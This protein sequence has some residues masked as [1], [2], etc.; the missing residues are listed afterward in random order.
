MRGI[1]QVAAAALLLHINTL[2]QSP[3][4]RNTAFSKDVEPILKRKCVMCHNEKLKQNGLRLDDPEAALAGGYSGPVILP[5]QSAKSKLI[6][7][8]TSTKKDFMMP[9]AGAPLTPA[10][11]NILRSWI[12]AGADWP[13]GAATAAAKKQQPSHWSF[14]PIRRPEIPAVR[15]RAWTRNAIDSFILARLEAEG[16]D[17]SPE[18]S[19]TALAR[20]LSL[21]LTGLPPSPGQVRSFLNDNRPNAYETYVDSLLASPHF[22]EKWARLWLDLAHYADSDGYEKDQVRAYAWR[23]RNWVIDA[24]NGDMPFD[25]F[26]IEQIA[27]DLLPAPTVEQRV[28]TGFHRNTLTNREAGVDRAEARFEQMVSRTSTVG[29]VWLGLTVGCAQC[30]D[31]KYDPISQKDF[32]SLYAFFNGTDERDIPAP[33]A[34]EFGPWMRARPEYLAERE[35]LYM[36]YNVPALQ[37]EWEQRIRRAMDK[38]GEDLEWDFWV[39]SMRAM[40]DG[41]D[42]ILRTP[43]EQ[44]DEDDAE[45]LTQYFIGNPGPTRGRDIDELNCLREL[46]RRLGALE[47]RTPK[48]TRA[49]TIVEDPQAPPTHVAVRGD[50]RLKGLRVEPAPPSILPPL[51]AG[52]KA[53]RLALARWLVSRDNPL[54]ARVTVNRFWQELFGRGIVRTS[55]DFGTQ[56]EAPS[57]PELLDW[58]A[59]DFMDCGWSVKHLLRTIVMSATYRQSSVVRKDVAEKDPENALLSRQSRLRMPAEQI[60]D[61]ALAAG[62]LLNTAIG[63]PSARPPQPAGVAE[64][65]YANSVKWTD[66]E[67]PARYRRGLYIHFQRTTPYPMLMNFDAPDSNVACSRRRRSNSPLQALNLLNDP[68]FFE[69]AQALA[70][71]TLR[72]S[73]PQIEARL[74]YAFQ[75]ALGRAPTARER[76]RLLRLFDEQAKAAE[77]DEKL[78]RALAPLAPEGNKLAETAA[79]VMVSRVLLNTDEFITRE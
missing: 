26:T 6:E 60:R 5:G 72:E 65:G 68:V 3:A 61:A 71:R 66:D 69:A 55:E 59:A 17:P 58:L 11:V 54:T 30:H 34:G 79:W 44:R 40:L 27:G 75:L 77:R 36:V 39:V 46:R 57:H 35:H 13:R 4:N 20:R 10:E 73:P 42:R 7:R 43:R 62:G 1:L 76:E 53:D 37:Q 33:L 63:G 2:A 52:A 50:Y 28:A 45:R 56:G 38:P 67:G 78:A 31:H 70:L 48:L 64:L 18:A 16:I 47:S 41:A 21:D 51:P 19:K 25:R 29:T 32:Y 24:F 74:D 22:G 14:Q 9:P 23:W 12:D 49:M 8:V 15:N